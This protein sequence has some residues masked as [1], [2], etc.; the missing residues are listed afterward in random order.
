MVRICE[1]AL[2]PN[3]Q[4]QISQDAIRAFHTLKV[5]KN[6]LRGE[7]TSQSFK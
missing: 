5:D 1:L 3:E 2:D 7:N 4:L 6:S